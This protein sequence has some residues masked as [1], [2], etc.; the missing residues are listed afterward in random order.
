MRIQNFLIKQFKDDERGRPKQ[1]S[2]NL[3]I[4]I[5]TIFFFC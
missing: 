1:L 3:E 5:L 2:T 4:S